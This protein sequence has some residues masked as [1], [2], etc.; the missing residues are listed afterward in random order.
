MGKVRFVQ[1][2]K[3]SAERHTYKS[4]LALGHVFQ[5]ICYVDRDG[6]EG[7]EGHLCETNDIP[8]NNHFS[9]KALYSQ[10]HTEFNSTTYSAYLKNRAQ[11]KTDIVIS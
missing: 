5:G 4:R 7:G 8:T 10:G 11:R 1:C 3:S 2:C 6:A 9:R